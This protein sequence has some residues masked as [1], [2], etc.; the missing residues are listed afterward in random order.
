MLRY[1][2]TSYGQVAS[3]YTFH[4]L[5]RLLISIFYFVKE[6]YIYTLLKNFLNLYSVVD[7]N[8]ADSLNDDRNFM[9]STSPVQTE[10]LDL[11]MK[12]R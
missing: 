6:F 11:S 8:E 10:P 9:N 7:G 4:Y 3:V 1:F 5:L 2:V 12:S